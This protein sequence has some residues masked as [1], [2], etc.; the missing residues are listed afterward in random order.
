MKDLSKLTKVYDF[1]NHMYAKEL[2]D[3]LKKRK[4]YPYLDDIGDI[5]MSDGMTVL[6]GEIVG[7]NR[8]NVKCDDD[9]LDISDG[10]IGMMDD[11]ELMCAILSTSDAIE[12][13]PREEAVKMSQITNDVVAEAVKKYP[14]R[15]LGSFCLPTPYVEDSV[16]EIDRAVNKLGLKYWHTHSCYGSFRLGDEKYEPI[17]AKLSELNTPFYIHPTYPTE[18]Y[19]LDLGV[20]FACAAFGFGVDVMKTAI[21]LVKG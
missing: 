19:L 14:G 7:I 11:A 4:Q 8:P 12:L 18:Q 1:E 17:F 3:L 16:K 13:L 21:L 10:R 9:L 15:F 2:F 6:G 20:A 5:H